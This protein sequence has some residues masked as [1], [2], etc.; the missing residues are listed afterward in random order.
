MG[1]DGAFLVD[2]PFAA[3][4]VLDVLV[5][6]RLQRLDVRQVR[7]ELLDH[8]DDVHELAHGDVGFLLVCFVT[9]LGPFAVDLDKS[10]SVTVVPLSF[11]LTLSVLYM[12]WWPASTIECASLWM[13]MGLRFC[14]RPNYSEVSLA[15][16]FWT[17]GF[18]S[19]VGC[20]EAIL[21]P[22]ATDILVVSQLNYFSFPSN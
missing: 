13:I 15:A 6:E 1:W 11:L 14:L 18:L 8:G 7:L 10:K 17:A 3:L 9:P 12:A 19:R 16:S 5:A 2:R 4:D 21:A 20:D 22:D